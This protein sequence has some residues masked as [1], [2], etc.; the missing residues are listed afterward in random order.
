[1]GSYFPAQSGGPNNTIHW[2]AKALAK[3][4]LDV[5]VASLKTGLPNKL[6]DDYN[7]CLN[8][9]NIVEGVKA[10]YFD[11]K[12]NRYLSIKMYIWLFLNIKKFDFIQLTSYFFPI[13][14]FSAIVCN[15]YKVPFAIAPR[16]ELEP[17][18]IKYN[19]TMKKILHRLFLKRLYRKVKFVWVTAKQELEFSRSYFKQSS[20]EIIPNY[21]DLSDRK[22][23]NK[24]EID[25]KKD[26]LYLG[27]IHPKKGIEN[28]IKSYELLGNEYI[29][30]HQLLIVGSG[31]VTY[32][33]QL[34]KLISSNKYKEKIFLLGHKQGEEK[35]TYYKEAKI[36]VLP[37]NSE[38]FGNVVLEALSQSTPV[39]ASTYTPWKALKKENCGLWVD[40]NSK[41]LKKAIEELLNLDKIAY[42]N[43][44]N[45]AYTY[46]HQ[47]FDINVN[48]HHIINVF[49]KYMKNES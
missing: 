2:Q 32:E 7:I 18:A 42:K 27:R 14:W 1:M 19:R 31:D 16:G 3:N 26:I 15:I 48:I 6:I 13:T 21:I 49:T 12:F 23:L 17:N 37:S 22:A 43:I 5:Y 40:N 38:N 11:Y 44:S 25:S 10:Y 39:I 8:K 24:E 36:F 9:E 34:R 33:K 20:F 41:E 46:V 4:K 30:R 47:K 28:L 29:E 45:N 35:E